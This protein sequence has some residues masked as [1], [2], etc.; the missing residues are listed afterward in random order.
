MNLFTVLAVLVAVI[1]CNSPCFGRDI[2]KGR[3]EHLI[4]SQVGS[5]LRYRR[6]V[7]TVAFTAWLSKTTTLGTNYAVVYNKLLLNKG[8]A[9]NVHT[10]HFTVPVRGLYLLSASIM[11]SP[12]QHVALSMVRN[13]INFDALYGD[14][15]DVNK[16]SSQSRSYTV[17]L[18]TGDKVWMRTF[19]GFERQVLV[20]YSHALYNSFSGV[21]LNQF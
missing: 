6:S 17:M 7:E 18:Q 11:A 13:G 1:C 12:R 5:N 3:N 20:G 19:R 21:L 15:R 4:F 9:Y 16:Y 10:G 2:I 8:N 14:S